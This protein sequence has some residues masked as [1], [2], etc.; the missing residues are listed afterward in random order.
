MHLPF[1]PE[2]QRDGRRRRPTASFSIASG[3]IS[4]P[5]SLQ[6]LGGVNSCLSSCLAAAKDA[7]CGA[8][9]TPL[10]QLPGW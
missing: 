7:F 9:H 8:V 2:S 10:P 4:P 5:P 1:L 3:E 6:N